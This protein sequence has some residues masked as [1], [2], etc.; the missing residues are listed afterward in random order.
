MIYQML[1]KNQKSKLWLTLLKKSQSTLLNL[2]K[3]P[4][5][6]ILKKRCSEKMQQIYS[7][8]P[9]PKLLCHFIEIALQHESSPVNLLH[10]FRTT[11]S[12]NTSGQLLLNVKT[13]FVRKRSTWNKWNMVS[14]LVQCS[15]KCTLCVTIFFQAPSSILVSVTLAKS[16]WKI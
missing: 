7:R 3:Q 5:R 16:W 11:F 14:I 15:S 8:T 4:S 12:K 6:G 9:M 13:R 1:I 2:Q 10:I